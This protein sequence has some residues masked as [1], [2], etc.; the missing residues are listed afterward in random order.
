VIPPSPAVPFPRRRSTGRRNAPG[1]A[2]KRPAPGEVYRILFLD[3]G[4][5]VRDVGKSTASE[6]LAAMNEL[7]GR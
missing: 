7:A 3:D 5:I 1:K 6:V 2:G 4:N